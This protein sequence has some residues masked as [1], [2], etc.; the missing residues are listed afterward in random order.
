MDV[1]ARDGGRF[2][3]EPSKATSAPLSPET[4]P[5]KRAA[6]RND[7][8]RTN[9]TFADLARRLSTATLRT[10]TQ[11]ELTDSPGARAPGLFP[12]RPT[13]ARCAACGAFHE[14]GGC[15]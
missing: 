14:P 4:C 6:T 5:H 10:D 13:I 2:P 7:L 8:D 9:R 11:V 1:G 15:P 3:E 12:R